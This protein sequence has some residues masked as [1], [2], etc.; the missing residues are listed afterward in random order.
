MGIA[1]DKINRY[2]SI[3]YHEH[4]MIKNNLAGT[5]PFAIYFT[6]LAIWI[7]YFSVYFLA[8][9]HNYDNPIHSHETDFVHYE[10]DYSGIEH[11]HATKIEEPEPADKPVTSVPLKT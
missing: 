5:S 4:I 9:I 1:K 6:F 7:C 8:T 2:S 3:G 10:Y 11:D